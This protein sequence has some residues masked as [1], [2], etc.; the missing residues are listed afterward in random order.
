MAKIPR[1]EVES[2][3]ESGRRLREWFRAQQAATEESS[4]PGWMREPAGEDHGGQWP[5]INRMSFE[6]WLRDL[7]ALSVARGGQPLSRR[8]D[9]P[10][11]TWYETDDLIPEQAVDEA[12]HPTGPPVVLLGLRLLSGATIQAFGRHYRKRAGTLLRPGDRLVTTSSGRVPGALLVSL[13]NHRGQARSLT[14][15]T[16]EDWE[17]IEEI[18]SSF[19]DWLGEDDPEAPLLRIIA[20]NEDPVSPANEVLDRIA[21]AAARAGI[22][23][24]VALAVQLE[25]GRCACF[26]APVKDVAAL[27]IEP[28]TTFEV[29]AT[30][31]SEAQLITAL[32]T[33]KGVRCSPT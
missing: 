17:L 18:E 11:S 33:R 27:T 3:R 10:L 30:S 4:A 15:A 25:G 26:L 2:R 13:V 32:E 21:A 8:S 20:E 14:E 9:L 28:G 1:E 12:E 7:D 23:A 29:L 19:L 31:D 22:G 6:L 16:N 24:V 5:R